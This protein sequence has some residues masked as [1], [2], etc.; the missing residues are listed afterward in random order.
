MSRTTTVGSP[1]T[2]PIARLSPAGTG[3]L[4]W[5]RLA[6]PAGA[7]ADGAADAAADVEGLLVTLGAEL[8]LCEAEGDPE[9]QATS[10]TIAAADVRRARTA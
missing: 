1:A 7:E 6:G 9:P 5:T 8:G 3:A 2:L 10:T 4:Q